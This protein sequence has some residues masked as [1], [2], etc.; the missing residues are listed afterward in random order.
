MAVGNHGYVWVTT[1]NKRV[2]RVHPAT[3]TSQTPISHAGIPDRTA[4]VMKDPGPDQRR[5]WFAAPV[6]QDPIVSMETVGQFPTTIFPL[7]ANAQAESIKLRTHNAG[8]SGT[9]DNKYSLVFAEPVNKYIGILAIPSHDGQIDRLPVAQ[10]T[11]LWD[12]A[13]ATASDG[14]THTYWATG[15]KRTSTP[16]RSENGLYRRLP[17]QMSWERIEVLRG[18]DHKPLYI[19]A[20]TEAVY[21]TTQG[22]NMVIRIS[23]TDMSVR[24][25]EMGSA[26]PQQLAFGTEGQVWVASSEGLHEFDAGLTG[27][28]SVVNLPNGGG[29]KGLCVGKDGQL[30]YTNPTRKTLGSYT[31]PPPPFGA[32]T[33]TGRTQVVAHGATEVRM[34][35]HVERPLVAEYVAGGRPIPG[36]PLTARIQAEGATF[37]DGTQ[38]R[39]LLT[40]QR[41]RVVLPD[42][43]AGGIE[44]KAVLSVGLGASEPHAA[45]MMEITQS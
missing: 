15:Q 31:P 16:V 25:Q 35:D 1:S 10:D 14:K 26:A 23:L 3:P 6:V 33:L 44:E 27:P 18:P 39:V 7:E 13:V 41:G 30:W 45:T 11:W 40:D 12:V 19:I 24:S 36:I 42:V 17:G 32:A 4:G 43:V 34:K 38:E 37:D 22:P 28:G 5:I 2:F 8:G 29:A 20:D 9:P 21:L